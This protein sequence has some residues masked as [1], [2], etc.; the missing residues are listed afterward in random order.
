[1]CITGSSCGAAWRATV[2]RRA[3][4]SSAGA[5]STSTCADRLGGHCG[6]AAGPAR[7]LTAAGLQSGP[8]RKR[9]P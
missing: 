1:M 4:A 9:R 8:Y 7:V 6:I 5:S 2:R 3:R